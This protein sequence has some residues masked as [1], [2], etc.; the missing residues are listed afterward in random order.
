MPFSRRRMLLRSLTGALF[1]P[2]LAPLLPPF[3]KGHAMGAETSLPQAGRDLPIPASWAGVAGAVARDDAVPLP[4]GT[5]R[6][7][8]SDDSPAPPASVRAQMDLF[9]RLADLP[10]GPDGHDVTAAAAARGV[11]LD[12]LSAALFGPGKFTRP[13]VILGYRLGTAQP[14]FA[15]ARI[16]VDQPGAAVRVT[17]CGLGPRGRITLAH[18]A[19]AHPSQFATVL[20]ALCPIDG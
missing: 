18:L 3:T 8:R 9:A 13:N 11:T 6:R 10:A 19:T 15:L 2:V 5:L 16:A 14:G 1:A 17:L 7:Y 20:A 4:Q 12:A